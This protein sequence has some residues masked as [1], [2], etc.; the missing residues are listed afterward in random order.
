[1]PIEIKE[2]VI[3]AVLSADSQKA[4]V[5]L[6]NM[7]NQSANDKKV[8]VQECVDQVMQILKDKNER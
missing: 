3:R 4:Q 6:P 5:S 1:M 8:I 2:L 7:S